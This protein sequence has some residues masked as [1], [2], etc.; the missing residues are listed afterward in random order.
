MHNN[1]SIDGADVHRA[2]RVVASVALANEKYF[3]DLDGEVGDADFGHS[4]ATGF[5]GVLKIL[6]TLD[7]NDIGAAFTRVGM[8]FSSSVGGTSGPIWGT[9]FVRAGTF[10]KGKSSLTLPDI[11][12]MGKNS[13]QGI[14]D[15]GGASQGDKTLLDA[16]LPALAQLEYFAANRPDDLRGAIEAAAEAATASVETTRSWTAKRGRQSY[17]SERTVGTLDPGIVAVA[18]MLSAVSVEI[19][20]DS[21]A[22]LDSE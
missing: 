5:R 7:W 11:V 12:A 16:M 1:S 17:A 20:S 4:L 21:S 9:A 19:C 18:M 6:P 22:V 14:M 8:V 10:S 15:R 3:C 13:V 2:L